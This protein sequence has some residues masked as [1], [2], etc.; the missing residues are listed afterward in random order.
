MNK[1]LKLYLNT[2]LILSQSVEVI[3]KLHKL[4]QVQKLQGCRIHICRGGIWQPRHSFVTKN[5][6]RCTALLSFF[7]PSLQVTV[8]KT[9]LPKIGTFS[10]LGSRRRGQEVSLHKSLQ[11]TA[12]S[13]ILLTCDNS[14]NLICGLFVSSSSSW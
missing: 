2:Y 5:T 12:A 1:G 13:F 9:H 14:R 11:H 10:S 3:I 6:M 8:L 4:E 7:V